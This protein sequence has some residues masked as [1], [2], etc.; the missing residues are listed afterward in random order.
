[1]RL[2]A[3]STVQL[4]L[5]LLL[6]LLGAARALRSGTRGDDLAWFSFQQ[7]PV[8]ACIHCPDGKNGDAFGT[9]VGLRWPFLVIGAPNRDGGTGAGPMHVSDGRC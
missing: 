6:L 2:R 5:A 3:S 8:G 1:M 9:A 4:P 7:Q